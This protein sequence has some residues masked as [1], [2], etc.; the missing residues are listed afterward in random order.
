MSRIDNQIWQV[1]TEMPAGQLQVYR[2][3]KIGTHAVQINVLENYRGLLA[4]WITLKLLADQG[5]NPLRLVPGRKKGMVFN[6]WA[7]ITSFAIGDNSA[8]IFSPLN[9]V[10]NYALCLKGRS[11]IAIIDRLFFHPDKVSFHP[12]ILVQAVLHGDETMVRHILKMNPDLSQI[13]TGID[14]SARRFTGTALQAA[15]ASTDFAPNKN[16]TGLCELIVEQLKRQNPDHWHQLFH[17]QTLELYI[18]SLRYYAKKQAD[19]ICVLIEKKD[20][21]ETIDEA[22][23]ATAIQRQDTYL[24]AIR[25]NDLTKIINAHTTTD[26]NTPDAQKDHAFEV[27]QAL[28]DAIANATDAEIQAILDNPA[29]DS[30]L[31]NLLKQFRAEFTK[32]SHEEIIF[33]PQHLLRMFVTCDALNTH[34]SATDPNQKKRILFWCH[35]VGFA[36]RYLPANVAQIFSN[37]GLHYVVDDA[38]K[39]QRS[40]YF[41]KSDSSIFPLT[42]NSNAG[43]GYEFAAAGS[44]SV[45]FELT[46]NSLGEWCRTW[47]RPDTGRWRYL[48][49]G[50]SKL[51]S[52]KNSKLQDIVT[53][54]VHARDHEPGCI[55]SYYRVLAEKIQHNRLSKIMSPYR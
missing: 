17:D 16:S 52:S 50:F 24:L 46:S 12:D 3:Q 15:V 1:T 32:L 8:D 27:D 45:R 55:L 7:L 23:L 35:L 41:A 38:A 21:G 2:S 53:Q 31:S 40:F 47:R 30:R 11:I 9:T 26:P 22:A 34:F 4:I 25:S 54:L 29:I 14:F 5:K 44:S 36:Q 18:K 28:I 51:I 19:K 10:A 37:P 48:M 49:V 42:F 20:K 13:G 39:N 33:N 6:T 43:F